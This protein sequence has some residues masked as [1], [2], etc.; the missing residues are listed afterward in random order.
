MA[1]E[2]FSTPEVVAVDL[3]AILLTDDDA[4]AHMF[5]SDLKTFE[6]GEHTATAFSIKVGSPK[7][8]SVGL[9]TREQIRSALAARLAAP[10]AQQEAGL[11]AELVAACDAQDDLRLFHP[12]LRQMISADDAARIGERVDKAWLAVRALASSPPAA[13]KDTTP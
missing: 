6:R 8:T 5:P 4:A 13:P 2:S 10:V 7:E 12:A 11:L 1:S 3:V 9:F